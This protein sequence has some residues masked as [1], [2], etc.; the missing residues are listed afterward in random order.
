MSG[1]VKIFNASTSDAQNFKVKIYIEGVG[2]TPITVMEKEISQLK[3]FSSQSFPVEF[4]T[5]YDIGN[6]Q[7]IVAIDPERKLKE[8][9]TD[10]NVYIKPFYITGDTSKPV[11]TMKIDGEEKLDGE[12]VSSNPRISVEF[13]DFSSATAQ[14]TTLMQIFLNGSRVFFASA[15]I[16]YTIQ[17]TNPKCW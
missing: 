13:F 2:N 9:F 5:P 1:T 10:N 8:Y 17:S 16:E 11:L 4:S 6:K 15:D 3:S 12:Y 7:F 14:D